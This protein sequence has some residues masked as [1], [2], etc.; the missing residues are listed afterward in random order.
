MKK[1]TKLCNESG[2]AL[3][4]ERLAEL[5]T[6][7]HHDHELFD[8]SDLRPMERTQDETPGHAV[9][10]VNGD[11]VHETEVTENGRLTGR[12][13]SGNVVTICCGVQYVGSTCTPFRL[14]F[15]NYKACSRKFN[16]GASVPQVEFFRHFTEEGHRGFLK[17]ISVKI[18][19]R[20]TGEIGCWKASGSIG[21]IALP[22]RV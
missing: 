9:E 7:D 1:A 20:V 18:I 19:D 2:I 6:T 3:T 22:L 14:R 17:D 15:N 13:V 5:Q 10:P 11:L 8:S 16:A 21:W 4:N 12:F